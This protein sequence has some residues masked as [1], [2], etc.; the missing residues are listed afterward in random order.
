MTSIIAEKSHLFYARVAGL[1]LL[2]VILTT[3]ILNM[4]VFGSLFIPGDAAATVTSITANDLL[5]RLG[6]A[7]FTLVIILEVVVAWALYILLRQ[8]D[9]SLALLA[10]LFRLIYTATLAASIFN[11][12]SL[13][14][15]IQQ[16]IYLEVLETNQFHAQVIFLM[17]AIYHG[18]FIGLV[19]LGFHLL[20]LG[21]LVFRSA[22]M[23]KI[24]G[25]LVMLAGLGYLFDNFAFLLVANYIEYETIFVLVPFFLGIIGELALAIWLLAKGKKISK[26]EPTKAS[27]E[28]GVNP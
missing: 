17:D 23:S 4:F 27:Y 28:E 12:L 14:Q 20:L 16:E 19:F 11:F 9:K 24:I 8:V 22:F 15:L 1:G 18:G 3:L 21:Y 13:L 5:F 7:V 10:A 25:I 26:I 6:I 2:I